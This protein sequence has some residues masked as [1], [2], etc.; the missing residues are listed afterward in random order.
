MSKLNYRMKFGSQEESRLEAWKQAVERGE[1][2]A[3]TPEQMQ[4]QAAYRKRMKALGRNPK[5]YEMRMSELPVQKQMQAKKKIK[6]LQMIKQV[7]QGG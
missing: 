4:E 7:V 1:R 3:L 5:S 2:I 6:R